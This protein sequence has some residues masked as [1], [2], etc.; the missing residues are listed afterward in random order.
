M[1]GCKCYTLKD[2]RNS[3]FDAKSDDCIFL[4]YST[5]RK[6]YKCLN[7]N[8][9][10]IVESTN[11]N[12]DENT[13][14][15]DDEFIKKLEE[16]RSFVYFYEGMPTKEEVANPIVNQQQV[17]ISAKSQLVNIELHLDAELQNEENAQSDSEIS[18][19]ERDNEL[20]ERYVCSDFDAE[21]PNME[22]MT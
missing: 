19:H 2:S 18:T 9:S 8:T 17:S 21:R 7:T 13:E 20:L 4:G 11:V 14:V 10:E 15:Q 1:F 3:K 5:R 22:T 6:V 12:F 16:Y